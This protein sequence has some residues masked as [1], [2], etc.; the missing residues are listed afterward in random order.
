MLVLVDQ[1]NN[2]TASRK[3][4]PTA[5]SLKIQC[6]NSF[7]HKRLAINRNIKVGTEEDCK[8]SQ[9]S[10]VQSTNEHWTEGK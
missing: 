4:Q 9:K 3:L 5:K 7:Q 8:L 1:S 10:S 2:S 6:L